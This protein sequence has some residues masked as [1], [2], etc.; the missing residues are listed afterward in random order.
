MSD[1]VTLVS[2]RRASTSTARLEISSSREHA[3]H[4]VA[5]L[6]YHTVFLARDTRSSSA[7]WW[8]PGFGAQTVALGHGL[9]ATPEGHHRLLYCTFKGLAVSANP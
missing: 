4:E 9:H 5:A 6:C 2:E 3:R 8:S 1:N 7:S